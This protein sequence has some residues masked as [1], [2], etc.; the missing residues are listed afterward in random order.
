[1]CDI[2]VCES[3]SDTHMSINIIYIY[4]YYI[5]IFIYSLLDLPC[6]MVGFTNDCR[7]GDANGDI[8]DMYWG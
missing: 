6:K 3:L 8:M 2:W 4:I 5:N 7:N 1:M